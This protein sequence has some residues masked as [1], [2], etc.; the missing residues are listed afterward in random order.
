[1]TIPTTRQDIIALGARVPSEAVI[2]EIDRLLPI[3][4]RDLAVLEAGGYSAARLDELR[5]HR[6]TLTEE[7]AARRAQRAQKKGAR[8]LE[9]DAQVEGL[10]ILRGAVAMAETA[11]VYRVPPAD[12][13]A[14]T[15]QRIAV[16][17][18]S[19]LE[20]TRGPIGRDTAKL[21]TRLTA[22]T[23]VLGSA[24][25]APADSERAARAAMIERVTAAATALAVYAQEKKAAQQEALA[26]TDAL[27]EIDG[28]AYLNLRMLTKVGRAQWQ[29][30]GDPT[31]ADAYRLRLRTRRPPRPAPTPTPA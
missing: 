27:D 16:D 11:I 17:L 21:R 28:R 13:P 30:A 3:A 19:A 8:I 1:M 5:G 20:A 4:E 24:S 12:E 29:I 2:A 26:S 14:E 22:I 25:I 15:T 6:A 9:A 7:T 18:R 23:A 31:R 10:R